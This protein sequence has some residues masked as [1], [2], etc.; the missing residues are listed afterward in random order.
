MLF[1]RGA[2]YFDEVARRGSIRRAAEHLHIVPSAINRQ[3]LLLEESFGVPLFE[4]LPQGMRLTTAG[5]MLIDS[6]RRWRRDLRRVESHMDDLQ[7]LRR[8][9]VSIALVEGAADF[10]AENIA[11]FHALYPGIAY[12]LHA[13]PSLNVADLVLGGEY[14]LGLTFNPPKSDA[15]RA[16][17]KISYQL[18]IVV[19]PDHPL[20]A[21]RTT[22]LAQCSKYPMVIPDESM[23]LRRVFDELWAKRI[24]GE[25]PFSAVAS[26][27]GI[28]KSM[29]KN[30]F[31]VGVL[32]SLDALVEIRS[33]ELVFISLTDKKVPPS[34]LCIVSAAGR[35]L[36][37]PAS[38][39]LRHLSKQLSATLRGYA[40]RPTSE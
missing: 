36:S 12:R 29:V 23:S 39:L 35:S 16:E 18:G 20:A 4:R 31:G 26:N 19:R 2:L 30:G 15:L 32:T 40:S 5:E 10:F 9:M 8:G 6:V 11:G 17:S 24:G 25:I 3:I 1:G 22:S 21:R 34:V 28:I 7:G 37:V 27:V 38:M 13:A 33:G 14:E